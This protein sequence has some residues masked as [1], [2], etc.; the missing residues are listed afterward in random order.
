[1]L[2]TLLTTVVYNG[3]V[4]AASRWYGTAKQRSVQLD[5]SS[6]S[7]IALA[8]ARKGQSEFARSLIEDEHQSGMNFSI[9]T[10]VQLGQEASKQGLKEAE[11]WLQLSLDHGLHPDIGMYNAVLAACAKQENATAAVGF[12][13]KA[14]VTGQRFFFSFG[15]SLQL[16]GR[17]Q[18]CKRIPRPVAFWARP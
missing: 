7:S 15:G 12:F 18:F 17:A 8:V 13:D 16:K 11:A 6:V 9:K 10:Y 1:M 2:K 4:I 3:D 14:P 5:N